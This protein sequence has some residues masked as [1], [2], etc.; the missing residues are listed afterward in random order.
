MYSSSSTTGLFRGSVPELIISMVSSNEGG[1][2]PSF[3]GVGSNIFVPVKAKL[4]SPCSDHFGARSFV[5]GRVLFTV[6]CL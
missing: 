6:V 5:Q 4:K 2:V 3:A 1:A